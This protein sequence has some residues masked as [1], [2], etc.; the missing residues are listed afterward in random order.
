[1]TSS[2]FRKAGNLHPV[3]GHSV[4]VRRSPARRETMAHRFTYT[5]GVKV[6]ALALAL[7]WGTTIASAQAT[8]ASSQDTQFLQDLAQ[9]SNYEIGTS[10]FALKQSQSADVKQY[11]TMVIHDHTQ[12]KQ[13]IKTADRAASLT[14]TPA[15][16]MTSDDQTAYDSLKGLSG[17]DFDQA[18]IKQ[19]IKGND[20][21]KKEEKSA[22]S[23]S[24]VPSIKGLATQ[25]AAI[26]AKHAE[27]AKQLAQAH[28]VQR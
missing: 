20:K 14:P 22:A 4:Q 11:A 18:Y 28:H 2:S 3:L 9:D 10:N 26:D 5:L 27:K 19:L 23:D 7:A 24:S 1:M 15:T 17:N 12:L 25:S 16:S 8:A 6:A 21:I 13:K